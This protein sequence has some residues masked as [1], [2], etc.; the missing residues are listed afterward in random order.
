M[1]MVSLLREWKL[2]G[3]RA[4]GIHVDGTI[5]KGAKCAWYQGG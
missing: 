1:C 3:T 4:V 2:H 5:L